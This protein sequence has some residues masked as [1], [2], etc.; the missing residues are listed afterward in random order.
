MDTASTITTVAAA[1]TFTGWAANAE[2]L[3]VIAAATATIIGV[4]FTICWTIF[5]G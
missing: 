2:P 4:I 5:K 1:S 3:F